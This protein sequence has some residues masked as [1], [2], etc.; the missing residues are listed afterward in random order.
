MDEVESPVLYAF[1]DEVVLNVYVFSVIVVTG[2]LGEIDGA[3]IVKKHGC[4]I[5]F[6]VVESQF[7]E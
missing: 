2:F 3:A 4:G 7:N 6:N 5:K 1:A